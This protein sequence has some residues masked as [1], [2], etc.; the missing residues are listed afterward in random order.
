MGDRFCLKKRTF[1]CIDGADV[2][3]GRTRAHGHADARAREVDTTVGDDLAVFDQIA[4]RVADH[5]QNIHGLATLNPNRNGVRRGPLRRSPTCA[6]T[7]LVLL[8]PRWRPTHRRSSWRRSTPS[9]TSS[10]RRA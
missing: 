5:N 8:A 9:L 6:P 1:E 4:E 2:G 7:W 3:F 10:C